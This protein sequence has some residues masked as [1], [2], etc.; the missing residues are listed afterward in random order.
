MYASTW[1]G[2]LC[3]LLHLC[4]ACGLPLVGQCMTKCWTI[5]WD[6]LRGFCLCSQYVPAVNRVGQSLDQH[7]L[8]SSIVLHHAPVRARMGKVWPRRPKNIPTPPKR[9]QGVVP[10]TWGIFF[11]TGNDFLSF[12]VLK[13]KSHFGKEI[14]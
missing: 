10:Q 1:V 3:V 9:L 7:V 14:R 13:K 5:F 6:G 4:P 12:A 11:K 2:C 8:P